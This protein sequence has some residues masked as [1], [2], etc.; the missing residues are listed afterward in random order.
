[1]SDTLDDVVRSEFDSRHFQLPAYRVKNVSDSLCDQV[2][3]LVE[4]H[5]QVFVDAKID[6]SD[7]NS[8]N[9]LLK[10]GFRKICNQVLLVALDPKTIQSEIAG[11]KI[12]ESLELE[13]VDVRRHSENFVFDRF[14]QD[15]RLPVAKVN[16]LF[17]EWIS[18][19][20][21]G[22]KSVCCIGRDFCTFSVYEKEIVI[23]LVSV[24]EGGKGVGTKLLQHLKCYAQKVGASQICVTTEVENER[25]LRL[26]IKNGFE[27][28]CFRSVFHYFGNANE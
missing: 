10:A 17:G 12:R 14:H 11:A 6:G 21:S 2:K 19:S 24:I 3:K 20:L 16:S 26:Y 1:M 5:G 18:N 22:S 13:Y 25:A 15:I 4:Q 23:D 8:Q 28:T 7:L 27:I 9:L